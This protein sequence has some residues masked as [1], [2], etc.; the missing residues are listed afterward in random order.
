[1]KNLPLWFAL[2]ACF[3]F[4][5]C[6]TDTSLQDS[7]SLVPQIE[8]PGAKSKPMAY[9]KTIALP[10][11]IQKAVE[12]TNAVKP[13]PQSAMIPMMAGMA[14]GDP[15]LVS[16]DPEAPLT[17]LLFDDFK[18]SEPTFVLAM[19][20]KP[21][22]PV[23]KQAQSIG[24]K[25]IEKEGWTLATMTPGLL[26]EVTD[27]SSVL[28]FA[29]QVPAEDIEA[30]FLMSPF[31]KEMPD[32]ENSI[33]QEI[34]S[35]SIAKLVQVVFE[36]FASLDATKVEL[37]LSAEEIMMRA[38]ASARKDSD[39]HVLFSSETKPFS[40]ESANCVSGGGWMDAVV[41]INSDNLL[42][43]VESVSG[44]INE[45][46]P[47]AKELVTRYLAIIREGTKMY[48]G[49]MAMSYGL[50]EEGNSLGFVQVG[51]TQAS[52]SELKQMLSETVVLGKDMLS[53]MD[54]LQ[55][56]G[57]KY[58]FEFE[59]SDPIDGV[60][61]FK[62]GMKM[63]AEELEVKEVLSTLPYSNSSTFFA[64]LD[65]KYLAASSK[66]KLTALMRAV[67][68]GKPVK[69]NLAEKLSLD[70]GEIISWRLNVAR[71]A[72]MVMS[73]VQAGGENELGQ[74]MD[75]LLALNIPPVT[76]KFSLGKGRLSSEM[77]IP[78]KSIKAGVDYFESAT[79]SP[80]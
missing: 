70:E 32:L 77:R 33:P 53:G 20:L 56:M 8:V 41:N 63:D 1:M 13:G 50:A 10:K 14:L 28:S 16:V 12:I 79:Q 23:A 55:S 47:D 37:S 30:G 34:G 67:K 73:M 3:F 42:Q 65:G 48:D 43:Y 58:D 25:T 78:V 71:Y 7:T 9:A 31:L 46:D 18:Q 38:T 51:S 52:P 69:N 80:F 6:G 35:P 45:K 22:S 76:G 36:E 57:L 74:L 24:L 2:L 66:D 54:A 39:L 64:V 26:E 17:V 49:Q 4:L 72:Q 59:E 44:R 60:E 19:K 62:L 68:T 75:G 11:L 21:D 27:W 40:P 29:G 15:A 61:V 5:G